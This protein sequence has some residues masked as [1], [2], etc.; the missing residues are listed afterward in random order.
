[1]TDAADALQ[2]PTEVLPVTLLDAAVL[3]ARGSD[4]AI[5]LSCRDVCQTFSIS[6]GPQLRRLRNHAV[7]RT[8][9]V[10]FRIPTSGGPQGQDF[11]LLEHVP[12]WLVLINSVRVSDSVRERLVWY[13]RYI[14]REVYRAFATLTGLPDGASQQIEDLDDLSRLDTALQV[15]GQRQ[16]ELDARQR[17]AETRQE[18]LEQSQQQARDV[19]LDLQTAMHEIRERIDALESRQTGA[20][21][22]TQRG[23]IYQL[24]QAWGAAKSEREP[25]ISRSAAFAACWSTLKLRYRIARYEDLPASQYH[26]AVMFVRQSYRAL[27]GADLDLPEQTEFPL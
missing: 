2:A 13:Q 20:I 23:Y 25:R 21:S 24:V 26:D 9:L 5:Y 16:S 12:T 14:I 4:G 3:A 1:M 10:R 17:A 8:G 11:L 19:W 22:S 6:L 7:L 15:L 27:T 18:S